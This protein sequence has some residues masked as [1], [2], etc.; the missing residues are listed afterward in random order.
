MHQTGPDLDITKMDEVY[1]HE[2]FEIRIF[3]T[4]RKNPED[5]HLS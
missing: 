4:E 3:S 1:S 5:C 2:I